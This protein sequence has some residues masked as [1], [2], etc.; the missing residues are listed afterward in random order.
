MT[1]WA[2]METFNRDF[3]IE[4]LITIWGP[5]WDSGK[6]AEETFNFEFSIVSSNPMKIIYDNQESGTISNTYCSF[7][8][9][10]TDIN[11]IKSKFSQ[12]CTIARR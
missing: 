4:I 3:N 8:V 7:K 11:D 6:D 2:F 9:K 10:V 5:M 12:L 1:S